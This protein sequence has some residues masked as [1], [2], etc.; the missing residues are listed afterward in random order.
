M[1]EAGK[2]VKIAKEMERYNLDILGLCETRWTQAG[3][4][5]INS[6]QTIIYS[7]HE[8]DNA[9]H[10]EGVAIMLSKDAEKALIG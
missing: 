3:K 5:K 4:V 8:E 6:G 1:Y 10:T 7:G 9:P 2:S